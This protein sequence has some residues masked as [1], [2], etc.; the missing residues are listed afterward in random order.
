[1]NFARRTSTK[2]DAR[3]ISGG[4]RRPSA[5]APGV[6]GGGT[7][8]RPDRSGRE[9]AR[10]AGSSPS[11]GG[12]GAHRR[13]DVGPCN[14][15]STTETIRADRRDGSSPSRASMKGTSMRC[16][17]KSSVPDGAPHGRAW[18]VGTT[19]QGTRPCSL[20]CTFRQIYQAQEVRLAQV[21]VEN[22]DE[23]SAQV[24]RGV[25]SGSRSA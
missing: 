22:R 16:R 3:L 6:A 12:P 13:D 10:G 21:P 24:L 25:N 20:S 15:G 1:M 23:N 7:R 19:L 18:Q 11:S 14:N 9:P 4:N 17:G 2:R 5:A 8:D